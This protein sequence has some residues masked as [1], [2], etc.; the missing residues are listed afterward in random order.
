MHYVLLLVTVNSYY[1]FLT[2][3]ARRFYWQSLQL[4]IMVFMH[5]F[6]FPCL[7]KLHSLSC[8]LQ[9]SQGPRLSTRKIVVI[10]IMS[11]LRKN[12][13]RCTTKILLSMNRIKTNSASAET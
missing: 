11:I 5:A 12:D 7:T 8:L 4:Y 2:L 6:C 3:G 1:Y 9:Y 13:V 10:C